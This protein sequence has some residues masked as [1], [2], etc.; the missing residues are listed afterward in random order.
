[1]SLDIII[2]MMKRVLLGWFEEFLIF[3]KAWALTKWV[4]DIVYLLEEFP[5]KEL[6][7]LCLEGTEANTVNFDHFFEISEALGIFDA[8]L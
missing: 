1:M 7:P 3:F 4:S 5:V 2:V 6:Y 8:I